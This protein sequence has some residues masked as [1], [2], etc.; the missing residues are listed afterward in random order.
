MARNR[1]KP[2]RPRPPRLN[3]AHPN[4]NHGCI[5]QEFPR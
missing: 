2:R 1:P 4:P 5:G 3:P